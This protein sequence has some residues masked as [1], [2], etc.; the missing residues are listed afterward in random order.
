[1]IQRIQAE[2][3]SHLTRSGLRQLRRSGRIPSVVYGKHVEDMMIHVSTKD[4]HQWAKQEGVAGVVELEIAGGKPLAVMLE[5]VQYD[6]VNRDI[7]HMDFMHVRM[8]ERVRSRIPIELTGTAAGVK[9]GGVLHTQATHV[10]VEC[11]PKD[12]PTTIVVDVSALEIGDS[13]FVEQLSL[14]SEV[15]VLSAPD[16]LLVT[17]LSPRLDKGESEEEGTAA[18]A[19]GAAE[20][21]SA[22]E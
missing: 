13:M 2:K 7:L 15:S 6:P 12:L 16:E 20:A 19:A 8:D 9:S 5:D 11:L 4:F 10:E 14:P 18:D 17:V 3:R 21:E 1:M 22:T